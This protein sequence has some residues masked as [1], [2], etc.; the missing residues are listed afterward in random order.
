MDVASVYTYAY[1]RLGMLKREMIDISTR[2]P[3]RDTAAS[4]A[5]QGDRASFE[6]SPHGI[7]AKSYA[8]RCGQAVLSLRLLPGF[9]P[10]FGEMLEPWEDNHG[11]A[12]L[13]V[14]R[15]VAESTPCYPHPV[16]KSAA[17]YEL[18][19]FLRQSA[20]VV[21]II[22]QFVQDYAA[23]N[24]AAPA[25]NDE[26][27]VVSQDAK[28]ETTVETTLLQQEGTRRRTIAGDEWEQLLLSLRDEIS[29]K[30][31]E[32]P[33]ALAE[34]DAMSPAEVLDE[35]AR[36]H[37]HDGDPASRNADRRAIERAID[38]LRP[39]GRWGKPIGEDNDSSPDPTEHGEETPINADG[40][41]DEVRDEVRELIADE[42][43][44]GRKPQRHAIQGD[45]SFS[46]TRLS[47][48]LE[49][50]LAESRSPKACRV[51]GC[52]NPAA[53]GKSKCPQCQAGQRPARKAPL[54][55]H[56][57][58]QVE[59]F[60]SRHPDCSADPEMAWKPAPVE[61]CDE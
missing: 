18:P 15:I 49:E 39:A 13:A 51:A 54:E 42:A 6:S 56:V 36:H 24:E 9:S 30:A 58:S 23:A 8:E 44:N 3:W 4:L 11:L 46:R 29:A 1:E 32:K 59:A 61:D 52:V 31:A 60:Y 33:A 38:R 19:G 20:E 34:L 47:K 16:R 28:A 40:N 17:G 50:T 53:P 27:R 25:S 14:C 45:A 43:E 48:P 5:A 12:W 22:Q 41:A 21:G 35:L 26:P 2:P 57:R 37:L 55:K 7:L 10:E